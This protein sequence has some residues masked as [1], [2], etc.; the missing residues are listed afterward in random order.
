MSPLL[1]SVVILAYFS[2]LI[3]ISFLSSRKADSATFYTANRKSPWYL[4]AFGM[5]GASLSGVTF[6]SIPGEVGTSN[7]SYFQMVLGYLVGYAVIAFVLLPVYY[8]MNLVSIY[9]YLGKR[10]G[11]RA[12]QTGSA[13]FL[14]SRVVGA[15]FRL[16]L[17]AGVLQIGLFEHFE[18]PFWITVA[19][20]ILLIWAYTRKAGIK[21][22]VFTDTLQTFFMLAAV[23]ASIFIISRELEL[24]FSG[25]INTITED[26]KS[27]I[28][29]WDA[30]AGT[31]FVKHFLSGAFI[32]I[33]MTGLDQD[34]MQKNLTCR[35]LKDAKKNIIWMSIALVPVNL[36]F[37][38]V[39]VLLYQY[40]QP[41]F[42]VLN[43]IHSIEPKQL[44]SFIS[45]HSVTIKEFAHLQGKQSTD[46]LFPALA[47]YNFGTFAAVMFVLGI[48]A[49]AFSSA[50]SALT[51]LTTAFTVDFLKVDINDSGKKSKNKRQI[52][53]IGFSVLVFF[54][55][56]LFYRLNDA[57]VVT[58]IFKAA[59]Y[60]YGP[61][62]GLFAYGL[63][64]K[65][66][67][68]DKY[69]PAVAILSPIIS[70][71]INH[72]SEQLFNGYRFGFELLIVNGALTFIGLLLISGK[73]K[74]LRQ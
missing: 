18:L 21:T 23:V 2:V 3:L 30:K 58:A 15:S 33:V 45:E 42:D 39:G 4:V 35:N 44:G 36:L 5:I 37:L 6:I 57:S 40:A 29:H 32:A 19:V 13:F 69:I 53:H 71:F 56:L 51:S 16:F 8:K 61:I 14:L 48:T 70:Y 1:F 66:K 7:F 41:A 46:E 38:S 25:L 54:V 74:L 11:N 47:L 31:Y 34:M 20:T 50:D 63:L 43:Q 52:V 26:P 67:A 73:S 22:I 62:L 72:Y 9:T 27:K 24:D 60:T 17:V 28:F 68:K 10:F 59:A 65:K 55:I 12:Y 64:T 49:A